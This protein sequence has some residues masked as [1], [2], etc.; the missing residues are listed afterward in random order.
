LF[1]LKPGDAVSLSGPYGHFFAE[2]SD[3]EMVFLGGGAGMAPLRSHI[4]TQL[5]VHQ[6]RRRM[7]FWYGARSRADLCYGELFDQL[8]ESYDNFHWT[9]ALSEPRSQDEWDGAVGFI[10]Q[11][12]YDEYL[13]RH[14]APEACVYYLCGPPL[15]MSATMRMLD[16]LGVERDS[17]FCDD[18]GG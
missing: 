3:R 6:T 9:A 16:S 17:I 12:A 13:G 8:A 4:L 15:M 1:G 14:E 2:D 5:E 18:F 7:S 10:H 11:V